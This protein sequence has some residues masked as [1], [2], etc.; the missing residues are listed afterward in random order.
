MKIKDRPKTTRKQKAYLKWM[1]LDKP[2]KQSRLGQL[3]K[4]NRKALHQPS[5]F[6]V[7]AK[8]LDSR[9]EGLE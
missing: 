8:R 7:M 1:G 9:V 4:H 5:E 6:V 2:R 3:N